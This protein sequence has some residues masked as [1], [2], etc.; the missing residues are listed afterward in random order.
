MPF[1]GIVMNGGAIHGL[2]HLGA[3]K[4]LFEHNYKFRYFAG[5]SIGSLVCAMIAYGYTPDELIELMYKHDIINKKDIDITMLFENFGIDDGK[6]FKEFLFRSLKDITFKDLYVKNGN[7]LI[8]TAYN[9]DTMQTEYF[10]KQTTPDMLIVDAVC[11]SCALPILMTFK[12]YNGYRYMDGCIDDD[13]PYRSLS[14]YTTFDKILGLV[15]Y[16]PYR[17]LKSKTIFDF[18]TNLFTKTFQTEIHL[19][20]VCI[21]LEREHIDMFDMYNYRKYIKSLFDK[22]YSSSLSWIQSQ[23]TND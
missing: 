4:C 15:I 20:I 14:T 23:A 6:T 21:T 2:M 18:F 10:N 12:T 19:P 11:M 5:S 1:E 13:L 8:V 3:I 17:E 16:K 9:I 22:G 7:V